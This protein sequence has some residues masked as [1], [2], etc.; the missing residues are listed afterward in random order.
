M[1]KKTFYYVR[2]VTA[3]VVAAVCSIAVAQ[4]NY[5]LPL[6]VGI[7]AAIAIYSVKKRVTGVLEDERDY[8][9][10]G[11]AA[12]WTLS[13]YTIAAAIASL[14]LMAMRQNGPSYELVAQMFAY[15]ACFLLIAQSLIFR[16]FSRKSN[17]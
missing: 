11:K 6:I 2:I 4:G 10:A 12:R 3:M 9:V 7:T 14:V 8:L 17:G 15:S 5:I 1:D 16:S 13:I